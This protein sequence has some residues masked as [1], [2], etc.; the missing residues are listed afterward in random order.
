MSKKRV[1]SFDVAKRAGVS[2]GVVS[3]VLNNTPGIGVSEE[4]R[5]AVL[6]AIRELNY[7]VDAQARSM[8][9]GKSLCLAAYGDTRQP[10]FVQLLE[11]M[12]RECE[13][14]GY[15]ILIT[16]P[17][18]AGQ[19]REG[20]LALYHQRKIDGI[21]TLDNVSYADAD[22]A[23]RV[24]E[25]GIPCVSVEGYAEDDG[26]FSIQADYR[27][28]VMLGLEYMTRV[29]TEAAGLGR[30]ASASEQQAA[31]SGSSGQKAGLSGSSPQ[32]APLY[33]EMYNEQSSSNWA[34]RNR[35]EAYAQWCAH[36]ELEPR[37]WRLHMEREEQMESLLSQAVEEWRDA[38]LFIN[39]SSSVPE[40][41]RAAWKLG[42]RIGEDLRVMAADNT[43]RGHRLIVPSLS[44][45]EIP[46]EQMGE[47]A[48][49]C[50]LRQIAGNSGNG[51]PGQEN[52][53]GKSGR[54][55]KIRLSAVLRAGDSA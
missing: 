43:I 12:Q 30:A 29:P 23:K 41:Y 18:A 25:A 34:E 16:S 28:S 7:H 36:R 24:S 54:P 8:R 14:Q 22:W 44:C 15:H 45:V 3:A 52:G 49:R 19:G 42:L 50:V 46:Y 51:G 13:A 38:G 21:V 20:L 47:E 31:L 5:E 2:R 10:L 4:T 9:T 48:V 17:G 6:D 35:R 55:E 26:M 33:V 39:W 27:G 32:K 40:L 53:S 11:G 37:F 1:T